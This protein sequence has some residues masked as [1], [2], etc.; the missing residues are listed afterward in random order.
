ML[1]PWLYTR[2]CAFPQ[3]NLYT[4]S[5]FEAADSRGIGQF[6]RK[7]PAR[8]LTQLFIDLY[9]SLRSA[10]ERKEEKKKERKRRKEKKAKV[11]NAASR[12]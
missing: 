9:V 10:K 7:S 5:L 3:R 4:R 11:E 6:A 2:A 12:R 1:F 8:G